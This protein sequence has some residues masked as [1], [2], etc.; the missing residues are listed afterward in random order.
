[1]AKKFEL[2]S[3]KEQEI[4][5][6]YVKTNYGKLN[7]VLMYVNCVILIIG[8][9]FELGFLVSRIRNIELDESIAILGS[10]FLVFG[11]IVNLFCLY[12]YIKFSKNFDKNNTRKASSKKQAAKKP[13]VKKSTPKKT[14]TK[15]TTTKAVKSASKKSPSKVVTKKTKSTSKK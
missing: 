13:A 15:S 5:K 3:E 14:S 12:F 10:K 8:L 6:S 9:I 2:S 11:S 1:M 7:Y 4:E